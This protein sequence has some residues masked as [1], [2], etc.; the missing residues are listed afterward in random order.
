MLPN[1]HITKPVY[2]GESERRRPVRR[3]VEDQRVLFP[4]LP[5][6]HI[7]EGPKDLEAD[8]ASLKCGN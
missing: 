1:H 7:W 6:R 2:I 4:A 8:W 5:G 3:G